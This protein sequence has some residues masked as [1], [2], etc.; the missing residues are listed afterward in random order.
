MLALVTHQPFLSGL[1]E[2]FVDTEFWEEL[3]SCPICKRSEHLRDVGS[4]QGEVLGTAANVCLDC[5]YGFLRRRPRRQWYDRFY[6]SEWDQDGKTWV[7]T[8]QVNDYHKVDPGPFIFCSSHLPPQTNVLD[9]GAGFG[10]V[11]LPFRSHG[12][13]VHAI[14]RSKHR[15]DY[16]R[17]VLE[18]PSSNSPLESFEP[19]ADFGLI[20]MNHLLMQSGLHILKTE[21][22][23]EIKVLAVKTNQ[24]T[25]GIREVHSDALSRS[26]FWDK[27]S[28]W[29]LQAFG[30]QGQRTLVWFI[31]D[32]H[33]K[34]FYQ[35]RALAGLRFT[36]GILKTSATLERSLPQRVRAHLNRF[37]PDFLASGAPRMLSVDLSGDGE[38]PIHVKHRRDQAPVWIK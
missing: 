34:W 1:R 4:V 20:C 31:D 30:N 37:L 27:T 24:E 35:R 9:V 17:E 11:L 12:H 10:R 6:A 33:E 13:K 16:L 3:D 8:G 26:A 22:G 7:K 28:A 14:E 25:D 2:S 38:L 21:E 29:A 5:E 15:A 19:S 23:K 32:G 36:P 18:I